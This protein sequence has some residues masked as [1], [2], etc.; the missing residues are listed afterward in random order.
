MFNFDEMEKDH[1]LFRY[2]YNDVK[3]DHLTILEAGLKRALP[4]E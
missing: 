1:V 3:K 2:G 4:Q